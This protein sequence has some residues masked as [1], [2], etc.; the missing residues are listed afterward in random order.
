MS[1]VMIKDNIYWV[2]KI[3]DREV[4]FHRLTLAKGTTYNSYLIMSEYPTIIDT[5]DIAFGKEYVENLKTFI[6]PKEI[7]YIVINHTEPDHSGG[8]IALANKAK[9]AVIVCTELAAEQLREM[10][11]L[12]DRE[13]LT[14]EDNYTLDIGG[15]TLRFVETPYLHTEETMITY[16]EEDK[17]LFPCDIF[18]THI[19]NYD[20]FNDLAKEDIVEDFKIYYNLIMHPHRKYVQDMIK[21]ISKLDIDIIAPSHGYI[22]R[23]DVK[24]FISIYDE[25]SSKN[26]KD[27]KALILYSTMTN[28]TKKISNEIYDYITEEGITSEIIDVNKSS[29]EEIFKSLDEANLIFLGSSTKYGDMIGEMEDILKKLK[30]KDYSNKFAVAFGSYGWSGEAIEIIQDYLLK[31]NMNTL[32]TSQVITSTGVSDILF[33]IRVKFTPKEEDLMKLRKSLNFAI[34]L[35]NSK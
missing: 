12:H 19:A 23:S 9:N 34:D 13:F 20:Y 29:K 1:N 30:N 8:L 7:K 24:K 5:V 17:I 18:S 26:V 32:S 15:K 6:D 11:K 16:L 21:K 2:G 31:T 10:Y 22:L 14:V 28:N 3:D 4:P 25:M 33:P 27:K 35:I